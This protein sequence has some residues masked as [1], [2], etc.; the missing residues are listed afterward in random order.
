MRN[1]S[2]KGLAVIFIAIIIYAGF[3]SYSLYQ[4]RSSDE[5]LIHDVGRLFPAH[6]KEIVQGEEEQALID[7]VLMAKK[8]DLKI[9]IAGSKHSQGGHA[10]YKDSVWL[11]MSEYDEVLAIDETNK[12]ITVQSGATWKQ[13]QDFINPYGLAIKVMQSSNIF[14]VGGSLS[15]NIHGRD[16]SYGTLIET[17]DSFRLLMADGTIKEVS[18]TENEELFQLVIGGYGLFGV[19]LDVTLQ[20]TDDVFYVSETVKT[21]YKDYADYFNKSVLTDSAVGLHYARLSVGSDSFLDEMFL[22]N[23]K[24]V[25]VD[26]EDEKLTI[27]QEEKNVRRNKFLFGVSRKFDWGKDMSWTVQQKFFAEKNEGVIMSRNNTMRTLVDFLEYDSSKNT[28]M[29]QEYFIP[30]ENYADFVDALR[31]IVE[32]EDLNLLNATVRYTKAHD[33]GFLNYAN[34]DTFA[35][36]LLFNHSLSEEGIA[37]MKQATGEIVDSALALRGTYYLT[38]QLFPSQQQIRAAYPNIDAFFEKKREFDPEERFMNNFY[39]EYNIQ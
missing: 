29:L 3:F 28:D 37:H 26:S 21:N 14:T 33:E 12:T 15:S 20:L 5:L 30:M 7:A 10:F 6:V 1:K 25:D 36:V 35:V 27:L 34:E 19:I 39:E 24:L 9:S 18:R 17:V 22:S 32:K 31:V 11:D 4:N 38:Y 23:Y 8:K 2:Y 13:I 16:P